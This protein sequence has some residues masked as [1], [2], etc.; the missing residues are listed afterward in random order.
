MSK[1]DNELQIIRQA[2]AGNEDAFVEIITAFQDKVYTEAYYIL[3]NREDAM[4][5]TQEVFLKVILNIGRFKGQSMLSTWI[6]RITVNTCLRELKRKKR[7]PP[8]DIEDSVDPQEVVFRT[9]EEKIALKI[10]AKMPEQHRVV[11]VLREINELPFKD[12]AR[13]LGVT[14]NLA[15]VRAFRAKKRFQSLLKEHQDGN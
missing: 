9:D 14:E 15:K 5:I 10:L 2:K 3:G 6:Y 7:R 8:Q 13:L 12:I 1:L 4:D 11:L